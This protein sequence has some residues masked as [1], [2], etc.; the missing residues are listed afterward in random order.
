MN[1]QSQK[2]IAPG[3]AGLGTFTTK[4][5]NAYTKPPPRPQGIFLFFFI[6]NFQFYGIKWLAFVVIFCYS[7]KYK[8]NIKNRTGQIQ[9]KEL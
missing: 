9:K 3:P 6:L 2:Y 1:N 8:I 5:L 4:N 7:R